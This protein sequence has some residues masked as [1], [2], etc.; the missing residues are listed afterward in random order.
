MF[1]LL[2][3]ILVI[4]INSTQIKSKLNENYSFNDIDRVCEGLQ[5]Y[6]LNINSL[7]FSTDR[8]L[9]MKITESKK[10]TIIS[11]PTDNRID[12]EIDETLKSFL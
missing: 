10:P 2:I 6:K 12:D 11:T 9:K 3:Q 5:Q 8:P 7:P 4:H 1:I